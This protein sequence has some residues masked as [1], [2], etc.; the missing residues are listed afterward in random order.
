MLGTRHPAAPGASGMRCKIG[1]AQRRAEVLE[2]LV[3]QEGHVGQS[4]RTRPLLEPL[5]AG[6]FADQREQNSIV[7]AQPVGR[8]EH[9]LELL[10]KSDVARIHH[11]ELVTETAAERIAVE[12]ADSPAVHPIRNHHHLIHRHALVDDSPRHIVAERHDQIGAFVG[13]IVAAAQ[14]IE[15]ERAAHAAGNFSDIGIKVAHVV[16]QAA[17]PAPFQHCR[18]RAEQWRIGLRDYHI[19]SRQSECHYCGQQVVGAQID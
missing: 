13:V 10:R 7:V 12:R 1:G 2:R 3:G 5:L 9:G 18:E 17:S 19:R 6:A 4:H 16:N 15:Q 8:L 14:Q 11:D